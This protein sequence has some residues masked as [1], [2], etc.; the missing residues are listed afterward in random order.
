VGNTLDL[1]PVYEGQVANVQRVVTLNPDRSV[2]LEDEWTTGAQPVQASWQWLTRANVTRT[3]QGLRLEQEGKTLAL[4]V[5]SS[6][7]V[8]MDIE[9]VSQPRNL[10]DSPN[11]GLSRLVIRQTTPGNSTAK[12]RVRIVPG[13]IDTNQKK[14]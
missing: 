14:K 3:P 2:L 9:D 1:T 11:P 7:E 10:Q 4:L 8:T 13:G 5:N 12:I 6:G